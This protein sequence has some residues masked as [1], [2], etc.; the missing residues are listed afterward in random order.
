VDLITCK[1]Q[2][3]G[4]DSADNLK[5]LDR[6]T[7]QEIGLPQIRDMDDYTPMRIK[8]DWGE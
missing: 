4:P 2:L 3:G 6:F 7:D 1:L 8:V 5:M